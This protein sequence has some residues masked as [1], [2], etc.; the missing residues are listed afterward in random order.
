MDVSKAL[1]ALEMPN[2]AFGLMSGF[3]DGKKR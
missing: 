2:R 1:I 3:A